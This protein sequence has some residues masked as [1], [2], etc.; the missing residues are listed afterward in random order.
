MQFQ[1]WSGCFGLPLR[2]DI[3]MLEYRLGKLTTLRRSPDLT[4]IHMLDRIRYYIGT[5]LTP[6]GFIMRPGVLS[7]TV[8][9]QP[10]QPMR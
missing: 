7:R 8:P 9:S 2:E 6:L 1:S 5:R 10:H 3:H 4:V